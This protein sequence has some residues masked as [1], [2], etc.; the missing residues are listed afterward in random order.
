[1]S[2]PVSEWMLVQKAVGE[3]LGYTPSHTTCASWITRGVSGV[4]LSARRAG[5]RFVTTKQNVINFQAAI[6]AVRGGA[7]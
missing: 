7:R 3:V 5:A 1:M 2:K 6:D 4:R